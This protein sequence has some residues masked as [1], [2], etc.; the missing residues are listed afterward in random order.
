VVA[1]GDTAA[2]AM[3]S[4]TPLP[5]PRPESTRNGPQPNRGRP[6]ELGANQAIEDRRERAVPPLVGLEPATQPTPC[7]PLR[8]AATRG[9]SRSSQ[10]PSRRARWPLPKL[11]CVRA[12]PSGH[13]SRRK[14]ISAGFWPTGPES[15][16]D[17]KGPRGD[18]QTIALQST[19]GY[20]STSIGMTALVASTHV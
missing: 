16:S 5:G 3:Q 6:A 20:G 15:P 8:A 4:W 12:L 9:A 1:W 19:A 7:G 13:A 18:A 2:V 14:S 17:L 11:L 10:R